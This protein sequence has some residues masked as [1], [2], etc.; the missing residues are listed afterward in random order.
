MLCQLA[1]MSVLSAA[2]SPA[3]A[4]PR[5][6]ALVIGN[7]RAET[8]ASPDLK[9]ADDDALAL[10]QLLLEAKVRSV[11]LARFDDETRA[12]HPDVAPSAPPTEAALQAAW[13][14]LRAELTLAVDEG[15]QVELLVFFSGHGDISHG[16]GFLTLEGGR[17]TRSSLQAL[18][19]ASP[20]RRNHVIIDACKA[21][22]AV[23]GKG[24]GGA[25]APYSAPFAAEVAPSSS[26]SGFLLST[27][28][29]GDSHEW[30]RYQAG[31]FS[32]EVRSGLRGSADVNGDGR[33]T[34]GELGGFL[35]RA[36]AGIANSRFRPDFLVV[37]PGGSAAGLEEAVLSWPV[38]PGGLTLDGAPSHLYVERGTGERLLEV[39]AGARQPF[40]LHLPAERPL[41]VRSADEREER[42]LEQAG[43]T[44]FSTLSVR[45]PT[46]TGKGA[47]HL[48]FS[49]LF[50]L[51]FDAAAVQSF[52]VEYALH[53]RGALPEVTARGWRRS[54]HTAAPV[55]AGA[56]AAVGL[57]AVGVGVERGAVKPETSQAERVARNQ[58][59]AA[60]NVTIGVAG[61][62][63]AAALGTWLLLA[64]T[65]TP[66]ATTVGVAVGP[67]GVGLVLAGRW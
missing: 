33:V 24:P 64:L 7:N 29:D 18:L 46:V 8:A 35:A 47:L 27:S 61:G 17:L 36:N 15:A 9:F 22:F 37:P 2:P 45:S 28:S 32:F 26:R 49:K 30:E 21:F 4:P 20:A 5:L 65:E 60:A 41:F 42:V 57:V 50:S 52:A 48:A 34:Y 10:H 43:R 25:R 3:P 44:A 23:L 39:N 14:A 62:V 55:V 6:F 19:A 59:I 12:L 56:A 38:D 11:L 54:L 58:G 67:E 66:P 13:G 1:L 40:V 63:T 53:E 16:E 51:P 31:V